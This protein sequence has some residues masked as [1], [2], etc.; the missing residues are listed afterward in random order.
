MGSIRFSRALF[1]PIYNVVFGLRSSYHD[2]LKSIST[3][4]EYEMAL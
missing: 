3:P 1:I 4:L 2:E